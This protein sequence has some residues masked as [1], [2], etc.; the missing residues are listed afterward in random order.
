[1][2]LISLL[3][4]SSSFD[5]TIEKMKLMEK[6]NIR[7]QTNISMHISHETTPFFIGTK[8]KHNNLQK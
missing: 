8:G 2:A 1:M 5:I 4:K 6:D 3:K 7:K